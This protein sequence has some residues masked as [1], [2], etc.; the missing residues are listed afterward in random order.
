MAAVYFLF[1]ETS[2]RTLDEID[3]VFIS[4]KTIWEPVWVAKR[5]SQSDPEE[6]QR[7]GHTTLKV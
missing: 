4:S 6:L 1:P 7:K 3:Q 2:G 5:L